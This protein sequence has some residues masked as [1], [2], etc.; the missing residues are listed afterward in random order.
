MGR[1]FAALRANAIPAGAESK[2]A[3]APA[4]RAH[5]AAHTTAPAGAGAA[6]HWSSSISPGHKHL[7]FSGP[8][9]MFQTW[10]AA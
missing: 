7:T 6:T 5:A 8:H 9:A 3:H 10:R 2:T 1:R 4:A